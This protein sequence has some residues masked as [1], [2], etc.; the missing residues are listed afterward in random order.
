[1][2][3]VENSRLVEFFF[4]AENLFKLFNMFI[5]ST[6]ERT[7]E[8]YLCYSFFIINGGNVATTFSTFSSRM[9]HH[10]TIFR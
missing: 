9:F 5:T 8:L 6:Y 10:C 7:F 2:S 1:M 3:H 4:G